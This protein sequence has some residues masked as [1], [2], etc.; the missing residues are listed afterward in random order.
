MAEVALKI[1]CH[2]EEEQTMSNKNV[3]K[4]DREGKASGLRKLKRAKT[5]VP[6]QIKSTAVNCVATELN[7]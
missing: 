5:Q 1:P 7:W 4:V 3:N 6:L 2:Q